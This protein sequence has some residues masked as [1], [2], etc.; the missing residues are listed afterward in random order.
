MAKK[1]RLIYTARDSASCAKTQKD[2]NTLEKLVSQLR[3]CVESVRDRRKRKAP[4]K[5]SCWHFHF[6]GKT[7][8]RSRTTP[9]PPSRSVPKRIPTQCSSLQQPGTVKQA[10]LLYIAYLVTKNLYH[11][12]GNDWFLLELNSI[13]SV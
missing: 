7:G 8:K 13:Q 10:I 1:R 6:D 5:R 4:T 9:C 12:H 2:E 3:G 11:P